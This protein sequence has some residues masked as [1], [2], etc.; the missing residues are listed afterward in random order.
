MVAETNKTGLSVAEIEARKKLPKVV[1]AK[2][3]LILN[4]GVVK[5]GSKGRVTGYK[6]G[7]GLRVIHWKGRA[8]YK[9][10]TDL[11]KDWSVNEAN[12]QD[13]VN[14]QTTPLW[15]RE[16]SESKVK[17]DG[18]IVLKDISLQGALGNDVVNIEC[19]SA[20]VTIHKNKE[21]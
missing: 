17:K 1:Y 12:K 4:K 14:M 10:T 2:K 20:V 15:L 21:E 19:D 3:S 11:Q 6:Q 5:V 9:T 7:T 16:W 13:I 8:S 18:S